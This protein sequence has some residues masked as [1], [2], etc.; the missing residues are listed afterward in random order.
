MLNSLPK[1]LKKPLNAKDSELKI[2]A[3]AWQWAWTNLPKTR[4]LLF[5]VPNGGYRTVVEAAQL[6]ASGVVPGIPDLILLI[7]AKGFS[8]LEIEVKEPGGRVSADQTEVHTIHRQAG[9]KV[10]V[11]WSIE[12]IKK[13]ILDYLE[14]TAWL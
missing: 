2:Q 6:K 10:V 7:P 13:E 9:A 4:R 8:C 1:S 11:C 12:E 5:H 3:Q 14:G